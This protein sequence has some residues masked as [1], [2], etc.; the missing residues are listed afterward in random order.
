MKAIESKNLMEKAIKLKDNNSGLLQL[1]PILLRDD[2]AKEW[3]IRLTDFFCFTINGEI[4]SNSL[5]R[6]G[7]LNYPDFEKDNYFML[8]E[9]TEALYSKDILDMSKNKDPKHLKAK[10]CI[11]DTNGVKK[12]ESFEFDRPHLVK[13]SCIYSSG[14]NYYNIE[15]LKLYCYSSA[16]IDSTGFL[17]L[18]NKYDNDVSRRGVMKIDKKTGEFELFK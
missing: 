5:Y 16:E 6:V 18:D 12:L 13:N 15:T 2:Y 11:F 10:W 1:S 17:F 4:L 9:Y 14:R 3:N 7:G 8:L